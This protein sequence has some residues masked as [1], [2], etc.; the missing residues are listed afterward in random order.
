MVKNIK[1]SHDEYFNLQDY[2]DKNVK[3]YVMTGARGCGK[4]FSTSQ[5]I[6]KMFKNGKC[7][8]YIRNSRSE[9][10]TARQYFSFL[11]EDK[12]NER[13]NLGSL[14][15]STIV[16]EEKDERGRW[17][18]KTLV[19][20]TLCLSDYEMLKSSKR[21][22]DYIVYEEYSSLASRGVNRMFGMTEIL[23]SVRQTN[24]N[25][26]LFAISNNLYK[27]SFFNHLLNEDDFIHFEIVK[28]TENK[29][30]SNKLIKSYLEGGYLIPEL[31]ISL[32]G[33]ECLGYIELMEQKIY[34]FK[35]DFTYPQ[36]VLSSKGTGRKLKINGEIISLLS[37][38]FYKNLDERNEIEFLI[39]LLLFAKNKLFI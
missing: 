1:L 15:A 39:G 2:L 6:K 20:Y 14:G 22:I 31:S 36:I 8:L 35:N 18:N 7:G 28:E 21:I 4:T 23:E 11:V 24:D 26:L 16:L 5:I 19:G 9:L 30:I 12:E 29:K 3:V 34:I 13:I 38:A 37:S 33:Y 27:D 10:S 32:K 25:Y 17:E